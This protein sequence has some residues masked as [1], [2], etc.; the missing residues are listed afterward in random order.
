M[1]GFCSLLGY[2]SDIILPYIGNATPTD[3][4]KFKLSYV[5]GGMRIIPKSSQ[6]RWLNCSEG[7]YDE[8]F[9]YATSAPDQYEFD[10]WDVCVSYDFSI[11]KDRHGGEHTRLYNLVSLERAI[12]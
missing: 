4:M 7:S 9:V 2:P 3:S 12:E 6:S 10:L 1:N 11:T 5:T 8:L